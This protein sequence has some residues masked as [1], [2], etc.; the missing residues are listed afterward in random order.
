MRSAS[1]RVSGRTPTPAEQSECRCPSHLCPWPRTLSAS[2]QVSD[3]TLMQAEQRKSSQA[4]QAKPSDTNKTKCQH[5]RHRWRHQHHC[6]CQCPSTTAA[7]VSLLS[8]LCLSKYRSHIAN[9]PTTYALYTLWKYEKGKKDSQRHL[10]EQELRLWN[11][12]LQMPQSPHIRDTMDSL[13]TPRKSPGGSRGGV[14]VAT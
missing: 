11:C 10:R 3:P 5:W 2:Q 12:T 1:Q 9:R 8:Y 14:L 7:P 13:E 6:H 4:T